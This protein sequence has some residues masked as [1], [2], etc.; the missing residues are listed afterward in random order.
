MPDRDEDVWEETQRPS[1]RGL[2]CAAWETC[3]R[4]LEAEADRWFLWL[5]VLFAAGIL[6]YFA[7]PFEPGARLAV[8]GVLA[9]LGLL[10]TTRHM[11]LGL[12]LGGACLAFALGFADAKLRTEIVRAPVL[13]SEL[14]FVPVTRPMSRP[15]RR[16]TAAETASH[17]ASSHSA[18]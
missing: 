7:L 14:R 6:A 17:F 2:F 11:P 16:A 10:L 5:P 12:A 15:S 9:A 18:I 8:A 1:R 3:A 4:G 13:E